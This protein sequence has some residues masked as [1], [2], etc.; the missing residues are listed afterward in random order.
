MADPILWNQCRQRRD[1]DDAVDRHRAAWSSW[2]ISLVLGL[3]WVALLVWTRAARSRVAPS[4]G[5]VATWGLVLLAIL[6][7]M[8]AL[9]S[10]ADQPTSSGGASLRR[11]SRPSRPYRQLRSTDRSRSLPGGR[12]AGLGRELADRPGAFAALVLL[13]PPLPAVPHWPGSGA[14]GLAR[15]ERPRIGEASPPR[16]S[17]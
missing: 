13:L 10:L 12:V 2:V 9:I 8:G 7:T 11:S 4:P 1:P 16:W 17:T 14:G 15:P 3:A 5:D 6:S